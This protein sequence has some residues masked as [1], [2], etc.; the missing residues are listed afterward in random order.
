VTDRESLLATILREPDEDMPRLAFADWLDENGEPERAEF[1]RVQCRLARMPAAPR[2][3]AVKKQRAAVRVFPTLRER[4]RANLEA[5]ERVL[6][7]DFPAAPYWGLPASLTQTHP[8][9]EPLSSGGAG[10][11][12]FGRHVRGV[13]CHYRRGF[14][15]RVVCEAADW[16]E[17]GPAILREH[18]VREVELTTHDEPGMGMWRPARRGPVNEGWISERWPGVTFKLVLSIQGDFLNLWDEPAPAQ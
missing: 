6:L 4:H 7:V 5:R 8:H 14:A 9:R 10:I 13:E 3:L 17:H 16:T 2:P 1:I 11:R 12:C 18:P 15:E